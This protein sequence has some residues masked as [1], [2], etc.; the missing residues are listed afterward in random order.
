MSNIN[1]DGVQWP[2]TMLSNLSPISIDYSDIT[3]LPP[4]IWELPQLRSLSVCS[5]YDLHDLSAAHMSSAKTAADLNFKYCIRLETLPGELCDLTR[6]SSISLFEIEVEQ[7]SDEF[8]KLTKLQSLQVELTSGSLP[9]NFGKL[10]N[11]EHL[12]LAGPT[13]LNISACAKLHSLTSLDVS[14]CS[15]SGLRFG[16]L[17][18]LQSLSINKCDATELHPSLGKL[19]TLHTLNLHDCFRLTRLPSIINSRHSPI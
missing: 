13:T 5:C 9:L 14:G 15:V 19:G 4:D 1:L 2:I 7:L 18:Q 8:S 16:R 11:L 10:A 17:T 12:C 3:A 6:L